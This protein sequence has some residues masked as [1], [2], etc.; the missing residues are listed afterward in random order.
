MIRKCDGA[1]KDC[2]SPF[3]DKMYGKG[4]RVMNELKSGVKVRCTV[5][6][7]EHMNTD[8]SKLIKKEDKK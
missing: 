6:R 3:Q 4:M 2:Y 5:C 1:D 7:R 8:N